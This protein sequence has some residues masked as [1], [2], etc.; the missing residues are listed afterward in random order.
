MSTVNAIAGQARVWKKKS[1]LVKGHCCKT[2]NGYMQNL[3]G[4]KLEEGPIPKF[5]MQL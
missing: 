3:R 2:F 5:Q 1:P 4:P